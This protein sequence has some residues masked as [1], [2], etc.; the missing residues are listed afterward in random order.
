MKRIANKIKH[1]SKKHIQKAKEL[2][3]EKVVI[4][5]LIMTVIWFLGAFT[6]TQI[7]LLSAKSDDNSEKL[8]SVEVETAA[9]EEILS[10]I[11]IYGQA[12]AGKKV[13]LKARTD[14]YVTEKTI[15]QG[16]IVKKGNTLIK[17][18]NDD[19]TIR[20]KS[21]ESTLEQAKVVYESTKELF[22]SGLSSK[23]ELK[24]AE[25]NLNAAKSGYKSTTLDISYSNIKAPFDGFFDSLDVEIG[26]FVKNGDVLGTIVK[27]DNVKVSISLPEKY[28]NQVK[29]GSEAR[30]E[31]LSGY[32]TKG[33]VT[34]ISSVA[35]AQTRT[36]K[37]EILIKNKDGQINDGMTAKV[38][39]PLSREKATKISKLSAITFNDK[40]IVGL[41]TV[42]AE[43]IVEFN[44]IKLLK[45]NKEAIWVS[46]LKKDSKVIISGQE[47]VKEGAKVNAVENK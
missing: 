34:Y 14:G 18:S 43:G 11:T 39:F 23:N 9:R 4:L 42:N 21:A 13:P 7:K 35:D 29:K 31:L 28:I 38:F 25:A 32:E 20:L 41:K 44:A 10:E 8:P 3:P 6:I 19:R 15:D 16:N 24:Q 22:K 2:K 46:G 33:K 37:V 40:G 47:Y 30:I 36:F 12:E 1:H 45:Q 17:L 27:L 26:D 5:I